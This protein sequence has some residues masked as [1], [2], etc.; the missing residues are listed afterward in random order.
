MS[1]GIETSL[2][3]RAISSV[4][5]GGEKESTT[6]A[7]VRRVGGECKLEAS[8]TEKYPLKTSLPTFFFLKYHLGK[9]ILFLIIE[10]Q[11]CCKFEKVQ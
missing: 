3:A 10:T 2:E 9:E 8:V 5:S 11:F 1:L 7:Q 6:S 4:G